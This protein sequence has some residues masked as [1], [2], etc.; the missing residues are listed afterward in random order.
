MKYE[1]AVMYNYM[2]IRMYNHII[3]FTKTTRQQ[4]LLND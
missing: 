3:S 1:L 2:I 4:C